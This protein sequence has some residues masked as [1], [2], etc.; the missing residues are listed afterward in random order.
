MFAPVP[1]EGAYS[2]PSDPIAGFKG[3]TSK[4][5]EGTGKGEEGRRRGRAAA[6]GK[7]KRKRRR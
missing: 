3:P 4:E 5:R 2:A 1:A 6:E 7:G